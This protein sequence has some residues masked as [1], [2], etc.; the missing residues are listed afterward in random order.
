[1]SRALVLAYFFPPIGGAGTQRSVKMVRHLPACGWESVVVTGPGATDGR[2][3]PS[4]AALGDEVGADVP[5]LRLAGS[6]PGRSGGLAGRA[7]RWLARPTPFARWWV[8]GAV[9][10]ARQAPPVDLV[11]ASMAPYESALAA[12]RIATERGVPWVADLRDPWALDEM[13]VHL[14]GGHRALERRRMGRALAS[15]SAVVMNTP[16]AQRAVLQ[17]FPHAGRG[18]VHAIPNGFDAE[19]LRVAPAPRADGR[20]RIVHTGYL[21]TELGRRNGRRARVD[22]VLRGG[23]GQIDILTRSHVHLVEALNRLAAS[24]PTAAQRIE[25]HLAGVLTAADL[26]VAQRCAIPVVTPGYLSH[27]EAVA[28]MRSAD[29]LFLPMHNLRPGHRSRIVPGKTYEYLATGRPILAAVPPGDA[30][31]LLTR[32]GSAIVCAPDDVA[33]LAAGI[34]RVD[35]GWRPAAPPDGLLGRYERRH[36][37]ARMAAVFDAVLPA[38]P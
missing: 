22:R 23:A 34:A 28:L 35:G 25:L 3:T 17:R 10:A 19:D 27:T 14:T 32:A 7:R 8:E 36:L 21:H 12:A 16:E 11:Y 1:M 4:D 24:D 26:E 38:V 13:A 2:W 37:A 30:R 9:A 5:V 33:G 15:A 18:R 20:L 31:D 29:L 6:P